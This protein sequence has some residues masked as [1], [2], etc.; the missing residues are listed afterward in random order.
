MAKPLKTALAA[1]LKAGWAYK[2]K[3]LVKKYA[4]ATGRCVTRSI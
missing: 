1:P 2:K 3:K 4:F